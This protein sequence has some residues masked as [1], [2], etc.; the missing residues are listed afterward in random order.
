MGEKYFGENTPKLGFGLMRLPKE[1]GNPSKID[2]EQTK[3]MV[4][5]FME[6]GLT[7]FDTAFVYD[8]G[9]SEK[10]AKIALV[11]R[12]PRESYTLATKLGAFAAHD[13]ESA[14]QELLTS[15]ERTGAGYIDYY[16]L[17]ALSEGNLKKYEEWHL[18]DYVK[19]MKEK[20][21]I[22]HYGF[23]FHDTPE[24]LDEILTAH[25]DAEFVQL[26]INYADWN[27]PNVQS[28]G[29]YE[30]ARKHG[31]SI[32]VMEPIK[33]GTL[34][35]PPAAVRE[36]LKG[37]NPNTSIASWAIRFVASLD[38]IIT[39]LS[40]MSNVEQMADN[41]SYMSSF[42]PLSDEEQQVISKAQ[43]IL[44]SIDS[45]PCTSCHYC[46]D[47]CPMQIPIPEIFS[48]R[49]KQLIWEQIEAGKQDYEKAT[50]DRG[51]ASACVQCGQCES[52]CPQHIN[53]IE[54]L[55]DCASVFE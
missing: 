28:R 24:R 33:G 50:K 12:Y 10:A 46:T 9:E 5:M 2:I 13:E 22:K 25:P 27:N 4:D 3:K 53:I 29:C 17:H 19:E 16:L 18:W 6:A 14:K 31:K 32:V 40:G 43:D 34:A 21:L 41:L 36:L 37:A 11:D 23:S 48:A 49:N 39:V 51:I 54:R 8:G 30:V 52:V 1:A 15:L 7:Y 35:N 38:G 45:I 20:G 47:G 44:D 55:Q 42:K 26:Q